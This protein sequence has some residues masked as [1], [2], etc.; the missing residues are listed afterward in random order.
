M[1]SGFQV[2][3]KNT[4]DVIAPPATP[5]QDFTYHWKQLMNFYASHKSNCKLTIE[6][7]GIPQHLDC[8]VD[9]LLDEEKNDDNP[10][11]CLEYLLQH[12][13]LDWL[14][15]L[16][17]VESPPGMRLVCLL[18][19]RKLLSHTKFP[20]LH[21]SAVYGPVQRL[22]SLCSG[23]IPSAIENEEVKFLLTLC[24]LVCRYP[25][26]T[27]IVN[28]SSNVSHETN[29]AM[30]NDSERMDIHSVTYIP[31]KKQNAPNALFQPLN[32][33]AITLINPNL[34]A[35]DHQRRRSICSDKF[36]Y[37]VLKKYRKHNSKISNRKISVRSNESTSSRDTENSSMCSSPVLQ[38]PSQYIANLDT[39]INQSNLDNCDKESDINSSSLHD[40]DG[41]L[42]DF[43]DLRIDMSDDGGN[44]EVNSK[45]QSLSISPALDTSNSL[46]LD[47]L[48]SYLNTAD[49]T[50]RVRACEG[51]MIL[52][53]LEDSN[54]ARTMAESDLS[55]VIT[56]RLENLFNLIPAHVDPAEIDDIDVTWGLDSPLWTNEKKFPGCRQV[57]AYF[58]W[59]DYCNQLIKEAHPHVAHSLAKN[60]RLLFFEK[61]LAPALADHHVLLI[62][63]LVTETLRKITAPVFDTEVGYWIV[64]EQR[65]PVIAEVC[66]TSIHERLI[67]NCYT[68][69]NDLTLETLKLFEEILD[70]RNEHVLHCMMLSYLSSRGYYDS[71]AADSAIASWSDEEDER[72]REKKGALDF[73]REQSHS[74]TLAPSNIHRI[75]NCFLSLMP[76]QL[77]TDPGEDNYERYMTDWEKQYTRVK[78]D[79]ALFAWPL[80]AVSIDDSGSYDSRPEADHCSSRFYMGPFISMLLDKVINI[81]YQKYEINL[82]LTVVISRLALLPHPYLHEFLLNPLLPLTSGSKSLFTCLQKVIKQLVSEV[83]KTPKYKDILRETRKH[84]LEDCSQQIKE[85]ILYESVV[86]TEEFCKELAAIAYVKYQHSM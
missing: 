9:I 27:N 7:T 46:L 15:T 52:A 20:L 48:I 39:V 35:C 8:L 77:Q 4:I 53:S 25:H 29:M 67:E 84:L 11:P 54:F 36:K 72:E 16:A 58:M 24:F 70:K 85:N 47:A 32:T 82:Q 81:P 2:A 26:L 64:G 43:E 51:I 37:D 21:Q 34:F 23:T 1:I 68:D 17:N 44:Y 73:S 19:F 79:C 71:G 31:A 30:K 6:C 65:D 38:K 40:V 18:F 63:S 62:T 13:L 45:K 10:G 50:V 76:R 33:Q 69:C 28:V 61:V 22:I 57:A 75:V 42:K 60:I 5:I 41:K 74:R 66:S 80:E 78:M 12:K 86:I 49:N 83:T 14:A 3:L 56:T 59:V 55:I